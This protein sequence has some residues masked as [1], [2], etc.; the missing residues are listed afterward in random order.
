MRSVGPSTKAV[1]IWYEK[2][3]ADLIR[4]TKNLERAVGKLTPPGAA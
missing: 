1:P 2:L 3:L 4:C